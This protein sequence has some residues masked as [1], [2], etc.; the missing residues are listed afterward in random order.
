MK[1]HRSTLATLTLFLG[2]PVLPP[3]GSAALAGAGVSAAGATMAPLGTAYA[4]VGIGRYCDQNTNTDRCRRRPSQIRTLVSQSGTGAG[5]FSAVGSIESDAGKEDLTLIESDAWLHGSATLS[6]LP[7]NDASAS[8]TLYGTLGESIA[9]FSG[10]LS[11]DGSINLTRDAK[12]GGDC[13]TKTG[14]DETSDPTGFDI[15]VLAVELF[16]NAGGYDIALDLNG[17]D[18]YNIASADLTLE[19]N[20]TGDEESCSYD[21]KG[22]LC[23]LSG[24]V[25]TTAEIGWDDIGSV[26]EAETTLD[27]FGVTEI[28]TQT[29]DS[30][31]KKLES[32]KA[33]LGTAWSDDGE[34]VNALAT[35]EDPL[36]SVALHRRLLKPKKDSVV[37]TSTSDLA[38][39][40]I[41]VVSEGWAAGSAL[42]THAQLELDGG[43]TVIVPANSYQKRPGGKGSYWSV[44]CAREFSYSG[45]VPLNAYSGKAVF[46][47]ISFDD[48]DAPICSEGTCIVVS[49]NDDG[50]CNISASIYGTDATKL[51]KSVELLVTELD[52]KGNPATTEKLLIELDDEIIA[53]F[54][55]ELDF[56]T[57]PIGLGLSGNV[58]LLGAPDKKGKQKTL[59]KGKFY[60]SFS[61]DGDGD[62]SLSGADKDAVS[63]RGDI[64]AVGKSLA[65][66]LTDTNRDGVID[67][68]PVA[69]QYYPKFGEGWAR[70][71]MVSR[72]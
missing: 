28:T 37:Y 67:G 63:S 3:L 71:S 46:Q 7:E 52:E 43:S 36:T 45:F 4:G 69:A 35:D 33:K 48:L 22:D 14:C 32:A 10:T 20:V 18:T 61:R 12:E 15:E 64:V 56:S 40:V 5:T 11:R 59:A 25:R 19:G 55:N 31:G 2:L 57:D 13:T 42:P 70:I 62:M 38:A 44:F 34:G 16:P 26:W 51:A 30:A 49:E 47:N 21:K 39:P 72:L 58:S 66:E 1:M 24:I 8:L 17:V 50:T 6:A 9:S 27:H 68:P 41:S 54:S 23:V 53:V 65:F 60:G 29:Y